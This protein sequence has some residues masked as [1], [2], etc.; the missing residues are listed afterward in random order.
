MLMAP[1][2]E[3]PHE[4]ATVSNVDHDRPVAARLEDHQ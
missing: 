1:D 2:G 4:T 3:V